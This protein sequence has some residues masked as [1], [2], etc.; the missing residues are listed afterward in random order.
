MKEVN[1]I[2]AAMDVEVQALLENLPNY[3]EKLI[4]ENKAYEFK[5]NDENYILVK[6]KIGKVY[7][8][9]FLS[10]L[11]LILKI[12]RVFNIG[13]SGGVN[14]DLKINDV[15]IAT[16]VGYHDVDV[17]FFN[18]EVGQIPGDPRYYECDNKFVDSKNIDSKYCK[19]FQQLYKK[20][21]TLTTLIGKICK[22]THTRNR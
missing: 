19:K 9:I 17:T 11:A 20:Q 14:K 13:T 6:G 8:A 7:T 22:I 12:K 16:K 1:L 2:V 18:Y 5:I 3:E 21:K 4:D 10:R 15:I